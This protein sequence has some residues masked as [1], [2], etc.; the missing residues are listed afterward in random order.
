MKRLSN[1]EMLSI[2]DEID[3][4]NFLKTYQFE[5][6]TR[7]LEAIA[8][9]VGKN[10]ISLLKKLVERNYIKY[11]ISDIGAR[12]LITLQTSY[13]TYQ[14]S[15][16]ECSTNIIGYPL[17]SNNTELDGVNYIMCLFSQMSV[18]PEYSNLADLQTNFFIERIRLQVENDSLVK[19]K[20]YNAINNKVD[21]IDLMNSFYLYETNYWK[22]FTPRLGKFDITWSPEKILNRANLKEVTHKTLNKMIE[23][24]REN[25][26]YYALCLMNNINKIISYSEKSNN[27]EMGNF[28]CLDSYSSTNP[29][30]YLRYFRKQNSDIDNNIKDFIEVKDIVNKLNSK[31]KYPSFSIIYD[32]LFKPSQTIIKLN[33]NVIPEEIKEIYLKYIDS[34]LYKGKIHIYDR[35]NRCVLSN[36]KK[37]DIEAKTYTV[38]DYKRIESIIKIK[39]YYIGI[40]ALERRGGVNL[41]YPI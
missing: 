15:N 31:T 7:L 37:A 26:V 18:L 28:C 25:S 6:K 30:I 5:N 19:D 3:M 17:I 27:R 4:I 41:L 34:G 13:N 24:G 12:F 14:I 32:P 29:Y 10:D 40:E 1:I 2:K 39:D 38:Q 22:Q 23:V 21:N 35:Y 20:I 16:K 8:L 36:E 9:K 11:L 33:F